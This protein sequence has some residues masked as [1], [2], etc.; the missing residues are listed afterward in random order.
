MFILP[1]N[2]TTERGFSLKF[3]ISFKTGFMA[4]GC[5][6]TVVLRKLSEFQKVTHYQ[7]HKADVTAVRFSPNGK[8]ACSG[9][10]TGSV[11][12]WD[13]NNLK[14]GLTIPSEKK[15]SKIF[16][17]VIRDIAWTGDG[18]RIA[19]VGDGQTNKSKGQVFAWD[20][21]NLMG[22]MTFHDK[23]AMTVDFTSEKPWRLVSGAEDSFVGFYKGPPFHEGVYV[24]EHKNGVRCIRISP[25]NRFAISTGGDH[26][27]I[28]LDM[29][30]EEKP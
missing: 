2:P 19:I 14:A 8:W 28:C 30:A 16:H 9:D 25:D 24:A 13:T 22:D 29:G 10:R 15:Q 1:N 11:H 27:V 18:K 4:Y 26:K 7:G 20:K 3:D 21:G 17:D 23:N 12:V 6:K 5:N